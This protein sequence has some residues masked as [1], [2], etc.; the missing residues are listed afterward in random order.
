MA[1]KMRKRSQC[2]PLIPA[3]IPFA[4]RRPST[5]RANV[6]TMAPRRSKKRSALS[7]RSSVK[8]TYL[9]HRRARARPPK[10][11]MAKPMLSPIMAAMKAATPTPTTLSLPAPA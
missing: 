8:N 1:L 5:K 10:C 2:M 9:P 11:P 4:W 6:M 7:N 3:M